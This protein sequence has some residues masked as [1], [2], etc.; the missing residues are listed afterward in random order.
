MNQ[1]KL[2]MELIA[3]LRLSCSKPVTTP[4]ECKQRFTTVEYD[5]H[6][7][8]KEDEKLEDSGP[9]KSSSTKS[10][11]AWSKESH[12]E[13]AVRVV[14]YIKNAP[15][16]GFLMSSKQSTKLTA[17]CDADWASCLVSRRSVKGYV[18]KLGDSL[19]SWKSKKQ[20]TISRSSTEAEY[21]IMAAGVA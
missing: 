21:R 3:E 20:C 11:H 14:R 8:W 1:R 10:V 15:R 7:N 12:M 2:A 13:A 16:L 6:M 18:M 17:F 4:M 9:Y 19:V 5:Q